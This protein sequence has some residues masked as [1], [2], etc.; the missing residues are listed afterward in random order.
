MS[1]QIDLG[2]AA[3]RV[4]KLVEGVPQDGLDRPTPCQR[5][6]VGDLLDHIAGAAVAF[7]GAARK[8]PL[9]GAPSGDA[10]NLAPDW[11]SRLPRDLAVLAEAWREP[12]A[13]TGMT[14]AGG[15]DLP[16]EV[17]AVVALD[18]LVIHGWD[19]AKATGQPADYDGPGLDAVYGMVQQ[20][21]SSGTEGLFGPPVEVPDD[22]P[23]LDRILGLAGR[24]P[25]W[26]PPG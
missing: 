10:A 3:R 11:R 1:A 22:A 17:A 24:D 9:E 18:E 15:V 6:R 25:G 21:R 12:E 4:A 2:P 23:L 19:L 7:T 20:F 14:R 26:T 8:T 5:Y 13:W 16:G